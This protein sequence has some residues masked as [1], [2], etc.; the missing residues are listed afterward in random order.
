[1][2]TWK[3]FMVQKAD[4]DGISKVLETFV[5]L[6]DGL[7]RVSIQTSSRPREQYMGDYRLTYLQR[8]AVDNIGLIYTGSAIANGHCIM[9]IRAPKANLE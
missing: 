7:P 3:Y 5:R 8:N 2:Q 9:N 1:M 6:S 4:Q